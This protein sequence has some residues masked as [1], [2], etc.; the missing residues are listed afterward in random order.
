MRQFDRLPGPTQ[1][2]FLPEFRQSAFRLPMIQL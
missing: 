1:Q 2:G